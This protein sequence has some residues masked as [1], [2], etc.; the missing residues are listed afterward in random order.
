MSSLYVLSEI[1]CLSHLNKNGIYPD[2]FYTDVVEFRNRSYLFDEANIIVIFT[3]SCRFQSRYVLDLIGNLFSRRDNEKDTGV[4]SV[5]VFSDKYMPA[6][7]SYYKYDRVLKNVSQYDRYNLK[8]KNSDIWERLY[9]G[10]KN[11]NCKVYLTG[12]IKNNAID[13]YIKLNKNAN[14]EIRHLI[15][16]PNKISIINK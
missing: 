7:Y 6:L 2:E 13:N 12:S 8:V 4:N 1:D 10:D 14:N 15:K 11:N 5:T 16:K 9:L 3:G